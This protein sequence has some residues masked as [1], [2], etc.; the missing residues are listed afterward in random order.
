MRR[1][2]QRRRRS[3]SLG[4][5]P[6]S[7][8]PASARTTRRSRRAAAA[9]RSSGT[10][11]AAAARRMRSRALE[12]VSLRC[13]AGESLGVIGENG[14]GKSTLLKV[15][16]G[17]DH[18]RRAARVERA[19]AAW[20]RCSSSAPA[21]IPSTRA[22]RTST[23][24]RRCSGS[25]PR[26]SRRSATR[27]CASPTSAAH[28]RADQALLVG[29]GRAPG[30]AVATALSPDVLITDEVLAVGDESFQKKCIAWMER[31]L[32]GGG[33]L[34]LCS[35]S[36]YHVQKLCRHALWLKEGT[37]RALRPRDRGD[38][39]LPRVARGE[40]AAARRSRPEPSRRGAG[41]APR[42]GARA[43]AGR[44]RAHGRA[45]RPCAA[46]RIR[47]TGA[48]RS[49][50]SASCAPTG[51]P[52]TASRP[53][54][55]ACRRGTRRAT[56]SR[57]RCRCRRSRCC[58]GKYVVRAHALDPEGVYL[59]DHVEVPLTVT[60]ESRELGLVRLEHEWRDVVSLLGPGR[61]PG[62]QPDPG[63]R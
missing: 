18:S 28:R 7:S 4:G 11:C 26:S 39:G 37:R 24:P 55:T 45:A 58:P 12:G 52:S 33:T 49:C 1:P 29:H 51:R 19:T 15:V 57:S 10:S 20:A 63:R 48:R 17:V 44:V 35:H 46:R 13:A 31:Y 2:A 34:L 6:C 16:A 47:P 36:M 25:R 30:F 40:V 14:A 59:F 5:R 22:R 53:T 32:A 43:R 8:S 41:R 9:S 23:S 50:W 56:G 54:W 21:S 61:E 62:S 27:S 38:A 42:Q 3:R 60:G